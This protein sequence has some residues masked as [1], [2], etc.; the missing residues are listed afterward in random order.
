MRALIVD[1]SRPIRR[2]ES[3]FLQE[4]GL[5][6]PAHVTAEKPWNNSRRGRSPMSCLSTGTCLKWTAWS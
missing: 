1:D 4:L 6:Q 2:I 5:R 3:G